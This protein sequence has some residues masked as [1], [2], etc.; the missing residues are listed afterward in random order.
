M[1]TEGPTAAASLQAAL[2]LA[3]RTLESTVADVDDELANRPVPGV[4]NPIGSSYAHSVLTEDIVVNGMLQEQPTLWNTSW[5]GKTGT[6]KPMPMPG[7]VPGNL[8]EWYHTVQVDMAA[9][10][11]YAQAV[12]TQ[13][14]AYIGG[15]SDATLNREIDLSVLGMGSM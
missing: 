5:A 10:R 13:A 11:A 7:M 2:V 8:G 14:E 6:D 9:C 4:A 1:S 15:A 12:Y 3:H